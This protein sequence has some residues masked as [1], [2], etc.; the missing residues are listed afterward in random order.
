MGTNLRIS[1]LV[2]GLCVVFA[3]VFLFVNKVF[4]E[5]DPEDLYVN[6]VAAKAAAA[7]TVETAESEETA[8][9]TEAPE[10]EI[11][12]ETAEET[13]EEPTKETEE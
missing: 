9:P 5:H 8:E 7:E 3:V 4:R 6:R 12:E 2:A 10:E 13:A 11:P 1:Q